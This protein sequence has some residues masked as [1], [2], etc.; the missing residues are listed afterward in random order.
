MV[1]FRLPV[2]LEALESSEARP[3][4]STLGQVVWIDVVPEWFVAEIKS[5]KLKFSLM[6][7]IKKNIEQI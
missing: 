6:F 7:P 5:R 1:R 4:Q 2:I 3:A